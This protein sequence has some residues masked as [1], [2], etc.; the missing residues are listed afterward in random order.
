MS[1]TRNDLVLLRPEPVLQQQQVL[2]V[3]FQSTSVL[4]MRHSTELYLF[5]VDSVGR[6][7]SLCLLD[8][9]PSFLLRLQNW[10]GYDSIHFANDLNGNVS[11]SKK[12]E[13]TTEG[14]QDELFV[15]E[16]V[17]RAVTPFIGFTNGRRDR[18]LEVV[19]ADIQAYDKVVAYLVDHPDEY[20]LYH[21][22]HFE[23]Q[24]LHQT[25]FVYQQWLAVEKW[26]PSTVKTTTC[27][28]QGSV[29]MKHLHCRKHVDAVPPLLQC[30]VRVTAVSRDGCVQRKPYHPNADEPCDRVVA[31]VLRWQWSDLP[32]SQKQVVF[33]TLPVPADD[34]EQHHVFATEKELLA[35]FNRTVQ[36]TD[37]DVLLFY[38]DVVDP[39]VYLSQRMKV[40]GVPL[41]WSRFV[42]K[43]AT[44]F[45][46]KDRA[47]R[48]VCPSRNLL[49][50]QAVLKKKTFVS[51]ESYDLWEVSNHKELRRVPV[52]RKPEL[53]CPYAPNTLI[54]SPAGCRTIVARLEEEMELMVDL[55]ADCGLFLE[56]INISSV[57]NTDVTACSARG[58]QIRVY[59]KLV[60]FVISNKH[61]LNKTSLAVKPVRFP[62]S[63]Y[64]PTYPDPA[65]PEVSSALRAEMNKRYEEKKNFFLTKARKMRFSGSLTGDAE[66][67]HTVEESTSEGGNVCVPSPGFY[68]EE[69]IG[70]LDFQSLY[71]SIMRAYNIC[72]STIV[73]DTKYLLPNVKYLFIQINKQECIAVADVPAVLPKLLMLQ[74][75]TRSDVK[76]L[77]KFEQDPFK[78]QM[79]DKKQN[80][81][82]VV[83]N[84]TYG[85]TGA[86][87]GGG[88]FSDT[89]P[90][91]ALKD[92]MYVVTSLGRYLQKKTTSLLGA[93]GIPVVYGDTDSVFALLFYGYTGGANL[94][95][96]CRF[97]TEKYQMVCTDGSVF[98]TTGVVKECKRKYGFD[99]PA[100]SW[101][102]QHNTVAYLVFEKLCADISASFRKEIILEFEC[103]A[104][105]AWF[106]H[107]KKY[108][109]YEMWSE[110][111][112][113]KV[114]KV[115]IMG[116]E[117]KKRDFTPWTRDVLTNITK[118]IVRGEAGRVASYIS[119]ELDRLIGAQ[120]PVDLLKISRCFKGESS[121]KHDRQPHLQIAEHIQTKHRCSLPVNSRIFYV[122]V[123]GREKLYKRTAI[124][125]EV[126]PTDIDTEYYMK[127]HF[128]RPVKKL[129][130]LHPEH[131]DFCSLFHS[132]LMKLQMLNSKCVDLAQY[133]TA[134]RAKRRKCPPLAT[135]GQVKTGEDLFGKFR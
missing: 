19:C 81:L 109:F 58:E 128:F 28:V 10:S 99:L 100:A 43:P 130:S 115:K 11:E 15:V 63:K 117:S 9:K 118:M 123:K 60:Q 25:N 125:E 129:L 46:T 76:K 7:V 126:G 112:P 29:R 62:V 67:K 17:E 32:L 18:M 56:M 106:I 70:V 87:I 94:S 44:L 61:Y 91:M 89:N 113:R 22:F 72:Y 77:M 41:A 23:N 101:F 64:P 85:Y 121:Y 31:V 13:E 105:N 104:N 84:A 93:L 26:V 133:K 114:E 39:L 103:R 97:C 35:A 86:D 2:H 37:P 78:R 82:K 75:T 36:K 110:T 127:N 5:G 30:F 3:H 38:A 95:E 79:L 55:E 20:V 124:P 33:T 92:I 16:V 107:L 120:V 132:K 1:L 45:G 12:P 74:V 48:V 111:D 53:F 122:F 4:R 88:D 27:S 71:P 21:R 49:D 66:E 50:M 116:M 65:E 6:S 135:V 40:L 47:A 54:L 57:C 59:N 98:D 42:S 14:E 90:G 108:Y 134:V 80:S 69:A 96:L 51:V 34:D 119:D 52:G 8:F 83:C 24:F 73:N 102:V 68:K 131:I